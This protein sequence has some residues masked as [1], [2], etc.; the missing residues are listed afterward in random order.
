M[1]AKII[2][3]LGM[4]GMG[5]NCD[6][7][8]RSWEHASQMSDL[9]QFAHLQLPESILILNGNNGV[10]GPIYESGFGIKASISSE[11]T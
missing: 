2:I 7:N 11:G 9:H 6:G 3:L 10:D 8:I 4:N 1:I 5:W